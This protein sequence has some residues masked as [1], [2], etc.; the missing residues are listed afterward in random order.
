MIR[1][2]GIAGGT[3]SGKSTLAQQIRTALGSERC[4]LLGQDHYYRDLAHLPYEER[5]KMNFDHPESIDF[6]LLC[7]HVRSLKSSEP[8]EVPQYD[9]SRHLRLSGGT[10][11]EPRAI[12]IVEGILVF[13]CPELV[14]LMDI[15]VFVE[16]PDD[17][18]LARRVRRDIRE[19]G[20]DVEGVLSQFLGTVR[21]M[22]EQFVAPTRSLADLVVVGRGDNG[23]VVDMFARSLASMADGEAALWESPDAL[24]G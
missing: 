5:G 1:V 20:R 22:H 9:F 19:R 21:P 10:E 18:R 13:S 4:A 23:V 3:A 24:D 2:V 7:Q 16:A 6:E 17:I 15:K 11:L 8:I 14:D 12:I